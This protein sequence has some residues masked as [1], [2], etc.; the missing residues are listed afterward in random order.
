M[1]RPMHLWACEAAYA[2]VAAGRQGKFWEYHDELFDSDISR[3]G[4]DIFPAI[5]RSLGLDVQR[6]ESDRRSFDIRA[7][8]RADIERG[9]RFEIH[10][11]PTVI[12]NGRLLPERDASYVR[13][14]IEDL[15]EKRSG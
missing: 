10:S 12:L 15:I 3:A 6:F 9:M 2:V 1:V 11:T 8:V 7:K 4:T 13:P 5:A 14:L